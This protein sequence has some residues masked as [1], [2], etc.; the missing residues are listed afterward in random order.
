MNPVIERNPIE[1]KIEVKCESRNEIKPHAS[2]V[3]QHPVDVS[4]SAGIANI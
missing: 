4:T 1:T 2:A 3:T